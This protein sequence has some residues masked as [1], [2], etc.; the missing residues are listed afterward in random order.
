VPLS[1]AGRRQA[2]LAGARLADPERSPALPVPAGPPIEIVHSPLARAAETAA[3]VADAM[4]A[5]GGAP[6]LRADEGFAEIGQGEWEGMLGTEV[7]ERWPEELAAWRRDAT[8]AHAPGGES[9]PDVAA[10]VGPALDR[11]IGPLRRD[12]IASPDAIPPSAVPGYAVR[13]DVQPW[14]IVVGH[15]GV[16]KVCLVTLLGL[17]LTSF[18]S[19]PFALAGIT[20][21]DLR[22]GRVMLRAHSLT[23]HL[24]PLDERAQDVSQQ[25]ERSG[26]L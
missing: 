10:R 17:P 15:D 1:E 9:L 19:L 8:T 4:R 22:A 18:W 20:V 16:F 7:A 24:A 26:A 5:V 14:S 25:R 2:A 12:P 23:E 11:V 6:R 21:V 3:A 13:A